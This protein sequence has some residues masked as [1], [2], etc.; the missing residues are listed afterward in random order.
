M[1]EIDISID[2]TNQ[3]AVPPHSMEAEQSFL[4]GLMLENSAFDRI[5]DL[6]DEDEFY[7]HEHS[8]ILRAI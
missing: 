8:L 4:C 1:E 7:R 2:E 5:G 3:L 6:I